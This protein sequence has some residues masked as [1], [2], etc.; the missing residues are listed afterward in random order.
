MISN[1]DI[2]NGEFQMPSFPILPQ[3]LRNAFWGTTPTD[4]KNAAKTSVSKLGKVENPSYGATRSN[5]ATVQH[6]ATSIGVHPV[7]PKPPAVQP[8]KAAAPKAAE[9]PKKSF[10]ERMG[11][12]L[13]KM[14]SE[15]F[16]YTDL[17]LSWIPL[18]IGTGVAAVV[19][20]FY[21]IGA[22]G[23]EADQSYKN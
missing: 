5:K 6:T 7:Q 1:H 21:M 16:P 23:Y 18:G 8:K 11:K 15:I 19:S 17:A 4:Q 3:S 12:R 14:V 13:D 9:A 20:L 10:S 22:A 2:K